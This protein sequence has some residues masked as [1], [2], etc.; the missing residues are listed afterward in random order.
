VREHLP[1]LTGLRFALAFWVILHHLTGGNRMLEPWVQQM[2]GVL[3]SIVHGGFLAV[4]TFFVLSGFVL[5]RSYARTE[6]NSRRFVEYA[7]ARY[8]RVYPVYLVSLLVLAPIMYEYLRAPERGDDRVGILAH[9][10]FV[11]QG[12]AGAPAVEWN[13]P[14]WSLSC[15]LFFYACFPLLIVAFRNTS[16]QCLGAAALILPAVLPWI[17]VPAAWK[18]V[19]HLSDFAIG[20]AA[21]GMYDALRVRG[22]LARRGYWLYAPAAAGLLLFTGYRATAFAPAVPIMNA[23]LLIGLAI[24]GGVPARALSTRAALLLGRASYSMYILHIPLLWWFKRTWFYTSGKLS[25]PIAAVLY[26]GCVVLIS[27][28]VWRSV[29]EPANRRIRAW[30]TARLA[31]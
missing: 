28:A 11:L 14:A 16:G 23:A 31:V 27:G 25:H 12:W 9:Y 7:A 3:Q 5:A 1:A 19:L 15:E 24:G 22:W 26:I 20:V 17:G 2:P 13:T 18:P 21:S 29:E 10:G 8:A 6:W 4:S 30:V